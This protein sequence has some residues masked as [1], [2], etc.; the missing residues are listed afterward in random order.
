MLMKCLSL[1]KVRLVFAIAMLGAMSSATLL[2]QNAPAGKKGPAASKTDAKKEEKKPIPVPKAVPEK[3][4]AKELLTYLETLND[5]KSFPEFSDRTELIAYVTQVCQRS[6]TAGGRAFAS[7]KETKTAV[8][9]VDWVFEAYIVLSRI[10]NEKAAENALAFAQKISGDKRP[11]VA[12]LGKRYVIVD[13]AQQVSFLD[14]AQQKQLLADVNAYFAGKKL[15][16]TDLGIA[17]FIASGI[18]R[19]RN[20]KLAALAY[21]SFAQTFSK[22]FANEKDAQ[23]VAMISR[24]QGTARRFNLPGNPIKVSGQTLDGEKLDIKDL[25]GK[26][27]LVDYWATWCGPCVA[28]MPNII[29]SYDAYHDKGFE[30]IG[31]SLDNSPRPVAEF[32]K[33]KE[34]PWK[35]IL[36]QDPTALGWEAPNVS[37]YGISSIPTTILVDQKGNVVSLQARG[38]ELGRLLKQ[39]LGEAGKAKGAAGE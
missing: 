25:K 34:I 12:S 14:E 5:Q 38:A 10:G 28:E 30:V 31:V 24:M 8:E 13:R 1:M 27:V 32:L 33:A 23:M 9:A 39:L 3:A 19:S 7:A 2:A 26:V 22:A 4:N 35:T 20:L 16:R 37:Y 17:S 15:E 36:S 21:G 6:V 18:E 29:A 11:E